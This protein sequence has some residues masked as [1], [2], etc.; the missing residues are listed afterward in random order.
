MDNETE[1]KWTP[2]VIRGL[3]EFGEPPRKHRAPETLMISLLLCRF[4]FAMAVHVYALDPC[5]IGPD[6]WLNPDPPVVHSG[7]L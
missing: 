6:R 5:P 7:G 1:W 2:G 3:K 4:L